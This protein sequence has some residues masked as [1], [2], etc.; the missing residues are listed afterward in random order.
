VSALQAKSPSARIERRTP[1]SA[2]RAIGSPAA[3]KKSAKESP[4]ASPSQVSETANSRLIG[5]ISIP[6]M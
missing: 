1:R 5:S 6:K 2:Q 3:A 4:D